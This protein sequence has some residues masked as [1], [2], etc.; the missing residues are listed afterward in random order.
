MY[1]THSDSTENFFKDWQGVWILLTYNQVINWYLCF[2]PPSLIG[3]NN[4]GSS[5]SAPANSGMVGIG[6]GVTLLPAFEY[7]GTW[8]PILTITVQGS[9]KAT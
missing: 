4:S 7:R 9:A 2:S 1:N 5:V 8:I 6:G 3:N